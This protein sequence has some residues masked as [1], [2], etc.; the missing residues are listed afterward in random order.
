MTPSLF[1]LIYRKAGIKSLP[2]SNHAIFIVR[3]DIAFI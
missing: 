2:L 3:E 1:I